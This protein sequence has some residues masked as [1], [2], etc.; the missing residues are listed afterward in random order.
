MEESGWLTKSPDMLQRLTYVGLTLG[1]L[2]G[3][4][5]VLGDFTCHPIV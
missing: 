5:D 1:D 2:V 4:I 3:N